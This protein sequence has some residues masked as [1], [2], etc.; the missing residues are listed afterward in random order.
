MSK[1]PRYEGKPLLRLIGLY[2]IDAAGALTPEQERN[3]DAMAPKL[4]QIY[5]TT[6]DWR[7]AISKAMA[8]PETMPNSIR[9]IWR[10]NQEIAK[11]NGASLTAE[12]FA[13]MF[14]DANI[15]AQ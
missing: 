5:G 11:Q 12:A 6:G 13:V 1:N 9:E 7:G 2:V 8:F 3:L 14:V 10:R 15:P 4:C